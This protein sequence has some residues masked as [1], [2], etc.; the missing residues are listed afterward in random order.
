MKEN[1]K[2]GREKR[3]ETEGI[4]EGQGVLE[5]VRNS[6]TSAGLGK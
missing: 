2:D 3:R 5:R 1:C 6:G 4:G